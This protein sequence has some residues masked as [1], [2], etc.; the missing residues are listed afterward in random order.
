M[1]GDD[2]LGAKLG[3]KGQLRIIKAEAKSRATL[4]DAAPSKTLA[5][6]WRATLNCHLRTR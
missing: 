2:V 1:R 3:S 4:G 5:K 6:A